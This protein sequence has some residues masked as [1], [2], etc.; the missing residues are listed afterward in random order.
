MNK[1]ITVSG[2]MWDLISYKMFGNTSYTDKIRKLNPDYADIYILP[3][4]VELTLPEQETPAPE[5]LPFWK[6]NNE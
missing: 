4:G 3:A 6:V 5:G 2:D 1:Y